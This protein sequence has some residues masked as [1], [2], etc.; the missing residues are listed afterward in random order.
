LK[1]VRYFEVTLIRTLLAS[2][3]DRVCY[4]FRRNVK[5]DLLQLSVASAIQFVI[6]RV[7]EVTTSDY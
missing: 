7:R 1:A 2:Q 3:N 5:T 6:R 4:V